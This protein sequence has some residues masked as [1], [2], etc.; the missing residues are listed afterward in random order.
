MA[1][2]EDDF[3][4]KKAYGGDSG[5][6][7]SYSALS[8]LLEDTDI[9]CYELVMPDPISGFAQNLVKEN[10]SV[11][12]GDIVENSSRYTL[13]HLWQVIRDFGNRSMRTNGV[14]YPYW[15]N[16]VRLT[17][18]YAALLTALAALFAF[19]PACFALVNLIRYTVKTYRFAK[20]KIPEKV[21]AAVEKRREERLEHEFQN[22][23]D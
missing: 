23:G 6:F 4:T 8:R 15:E 9:S 2:R 13:G 17:E 11:G 16:A 21:E 20:T 5:I 7:M 1:A 22:K 19:Y 10:F 12:S 14:I 18:D 3:A